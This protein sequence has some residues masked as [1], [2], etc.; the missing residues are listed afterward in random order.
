LQQKI[1]QENPDIVILVEFSD[2]HENE[3]K[4]FFKENYPYMNRNSR[5]ITLAGDVVFSKIPL[6]NIT[7]THIVEA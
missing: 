2:N 5:S 7:E 3:M 4:Q 6:E 1:E